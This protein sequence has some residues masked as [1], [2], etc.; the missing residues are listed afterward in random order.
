[1]T[2]IAHE[3]V[4][5]HLC[6]KYQPDQIPNKEDDQ[7]MS[8]RNLHIATWL[9]Y[10]RYS[11][12]QRNFPSPFLCFENHLFHV[13]C[14]KRPLLPTPTTHTYSSHVLPWHTCFYTLDHAIAATPS[15]PP[16]PQ[17]RRV[18]S[19]YQSHA[20]E[21]LMASNCWPQTFCRKNCIT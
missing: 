9:I 7:T 19:C 13:G 3:L 15:P 14:V 12:F 10:S 6:R 17:T 20:T 4:G 21:R 18:T 1:M 16:P 8:H 5:L 11:R 2:N